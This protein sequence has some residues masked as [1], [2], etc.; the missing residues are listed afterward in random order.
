MLFKPFEYMY[1][2]GLRPARNHLRKTLMANEKLQKKKKIIKYVVKN[3][4]EE[5]VT[6]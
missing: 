2:L 3:L 6:Y 5:A 1:S 4:L